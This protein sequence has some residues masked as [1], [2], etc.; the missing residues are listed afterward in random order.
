MMVELIIIL[1]LRNLKSMAENSNM[2]TWDITSK[3]F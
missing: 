1:I 2:L 3:S